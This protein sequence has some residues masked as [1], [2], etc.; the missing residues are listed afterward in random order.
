MLLTRGERE[1]GWLRGVGVSVGV[2]YTWM[3]WFGERKEWGLGACLVACGVWIEDFY[4]CSEYVH[5]RVRCTPTSLCIYLS[6]SLFLAI[7]LSRLPLPER[8]RTR[9]RKRGGGGEGAGPS[10]GSD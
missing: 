8:K 5:V 1:S 9:R 4:I 3:V 10:F 2:D 7:W 6:L